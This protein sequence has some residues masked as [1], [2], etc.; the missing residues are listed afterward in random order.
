MP[1]Q[2][3]LQLATRCCTTLCATMGNKARQLMLKGSS[4][5]TGSAS[6]TLHV[7]RSRVRHRNAVH[8]RSRRAV[9]RGTYHRDDADLGRSPS[10]ARR[11]RL[12]DGPRSH[13][14]N[15][16]PSRAIASS[17]FA[18]CRRSMRRYSAACTQKTIRV[19]RTS[20]G[21][22][23]Y[24]RGRYGCG[25]IYKPWVD[26]CAEDIRGLAVVRWHSDV[27]ASTGCCSSIE[28]TAKLP[29]SMPRLLS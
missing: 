8:L 18:R 3:Q 2:M 4:K 27:T 20:L 1:A 5:S 13:G 25:H 29:N 15:C 16:K 14:V 26:N 9:S 7:A 24:L 6:S 21:R 28:C 19:V 10:R 11:H 12:R 22:P 23:E 17:Q